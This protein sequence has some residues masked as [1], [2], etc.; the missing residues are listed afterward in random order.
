MAQH[1]ALTTDEF[2]R[3]FRRCAPTLWCVA[4]A[5][6]GDRDRAQDVLQEA[7]MI[8]LGKLDAYE[9]GTSFRAWLAQIV[10]Y[11]ALNQRRRTARRREVPSA[12]PR[13]ELV[14][15]DPAPLG[16]SAGGELREDQRHFDDTVVAALD[17][18]AAGY[19]I[20]PNQCAYVGDDMPDLPLLTHVG[21]SI[22]VANAVPALLEQCDH[23]TRASGGAGAVREVCELILGSMGQSPA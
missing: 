3:R 12:P 13:L 1:D 23:T 7:A 16:V 18:I 15:R 20:S 10:R 17:E 2:A 5:I 9:P 11:V 14:E 6:V 21:V 8:A 4:A 19:D 22:A